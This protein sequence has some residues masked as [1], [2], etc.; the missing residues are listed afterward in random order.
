MSSNFETS[1]PLVFTD[2]PYY[3]FPDSRLCEENDQISHSFFYQCIARKCRSSREIILSGLYYVSLVERFVFVFAVNINERKVETTR[4]L[5]TFCFFFSICFCIY[6]AFLL[7]NQRFRHDIRRIPLRYE[8]V[9][10][11]FFF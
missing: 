6:L 10:F 1:L 8:G 11:I 5:E 4:Y 2:I 9:F 3:D 7:I